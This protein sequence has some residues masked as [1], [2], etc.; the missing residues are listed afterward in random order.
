MLA[1]GVHGPKVAQ[2][3]RPVP[4]KSFASV[5]EA[6]AGR[7]VLPQAIG[8]LACFASAEYFC[9]YAFIPC[10]ILFINKKLD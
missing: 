7:V 5:C 2:Q 9:L 4:A 3:K 10:N 8:M 6:T 1:G